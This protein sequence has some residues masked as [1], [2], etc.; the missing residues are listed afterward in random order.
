MGDH[1]A[2]ARA[3]IYKEELDAYRARIEQL[4]KE[5]TRLEE[6]MRYYD[7]FR[8]PYLSVPLGEAAPVSDVSAP[9]DPTAPQGARIKKRKPPKTEK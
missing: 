4:V 3:E 9:F 7:D 5:N 1:G 6:R 8:K 2:A